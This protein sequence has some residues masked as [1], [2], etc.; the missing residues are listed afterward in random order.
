MKY[1]YKLAEIFTKYPKLYQSLCEAP[2]IQKCVAMQKYVAGDIYF[3]NMM[4]VRPVNLVKTLREILTRKDD[5]HISEGECINL[6]TNWLIPT[7]DIVCKSDAISKN[8]SSANVMINSKGEFLE[9][10]W[11]LHECLPIPEFNLD[12]KLKLIHVH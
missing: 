9:I 5:K 8:N 12:A 4:W 1:D 3:S 7:W 2:S 6:C 11:L 10:F